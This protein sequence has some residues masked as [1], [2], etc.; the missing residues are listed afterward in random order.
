MYIIAHD[1]GTTGNKAALLDP[2]GK[3][4][5]SA[6]QTYNTFYPNPLQV[7]QNPDDW[8]NAVKRCT[9]ELLQNHPIHDPCVLSFSG[10][11]MGCL[12]VDKSG[13]PLNNALIWADQRSGR[14][15]QQLQDKIDP[16]EVY[17]IT[18]HRLSPSY[19]LGKW[20]W[21]QENNR[22]A[23]LITHKILQAKDYIIY[24][25]TGRFVTDLSDASGTNLFDLEKSEWSESLAEAAGVDINILPEVLPSATVV[26]TLS[27]EAADILGLSPKSI[28]AAGAGDGIAAAIGAGCVEPGSFYNYLGSSSWV[29][30][31]SNKPVY[32]PEMRTFTWAHA[33]PGLYSPCGTMQA[34]GNSLNWM[35]NAIGKGS[36][37]DINKAA[38]ASPPGARGLLFL[39]YL[40]GERSPWW[41][42]DA[43][44]SFLG[45]T[46]E[47]S[48][49]DLYRAVIEGVSLNLGIIKSL[50]VQDPPSIRIL[51]GGTASELWLQIL[52]DIYQCPI[53]PV[54]NPES[55]TSV[56][57]A[58]IGGIAAGIFEGYGK[59]HELIQLDGTIKHRSEN[60]SLYKKK[61]DLLKRCYQALEPV[62]SQQ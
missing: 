49:S 12:P 41:N 19:S 61:E 10:Q 33:E 9:R 52:A 37:E 13:T 56:G 4:I 22:E 30:G 35:K 1:L 58:I 26:G 14:Q 60:F 32:D 11:M 54:K 5:G 23:S 29:A 50:I 2:Q 53:Q 40:L 43:T 59:V 3:L 18:G 24:K 28:V 21:F 44:G 17:S 27:K 51:G 62:F 57:A 20:L 55:A 45:I 31:T 7:E 25:L 16:W 47:H 38:E 36:W 48:H 39:P 15:I 6:T 42:T 46:M 8:W 34:A